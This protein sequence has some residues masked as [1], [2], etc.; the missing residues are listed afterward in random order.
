[1]PQLSSPRPLFLGVFLAVLGAVVW[2]VAIRPAPPNAPPATAPALEMVNDVQPDPA[3]DDPRLVFNTPFRNIKPGVN[4]VGDSRCAECHLDIC[5]SYHAH[6]MGR[7]AA[8]V[9]D[10]SPLEKYDPKSG[11]PF[12]SGVYQL[13][14]TRT[15]TGV[16]H[17]MTAKDIDGVALPEYATAANLA[18]G[19][20]TRGRSYVS[21]ENGSVWQ[22]PVSWFTS[23]SKW[24]L[25]PGFDLGS[26]GRRPI[27]A[28]C[29]LCHVNHVEAVRG[30]V[31]VYKEPLIALQ[32]S[33]GCERCH[34]P[35]DLHVSERLVGK[36]KEKIDTSIVNPKHLASDLQAS[37][38]QQCHLQGQERVRRRGRD[39]SEY[40]PGL[41]FDSFVTT[42]VRHPDLVEAN[43]SVGQFEQMEQS[44]CKTSTGGKLLCTSCH[45]PHKAPA[46]ADKEA[47][48]RNACQKCHETKGCVAPQAE[49][50]QKNDSCVACHMPKAGSS[51]IAHASVTDHRIQRRPVPPP[52]P[53]GMPPGE[54]PLSVF[55][56]GKVPEAEVKRDLGIALSRLT[57]KLP[58]GNSRQMLGAQAREVIGAALQKF[59]GDA[60]SWLAMAKSQAA[61]GDRNERWRCAERAVILEPN[62]EFALD[63]LVE[64]AMD[65]KRYDRA[66]EAADRLVSMNPRA[67]D[68][69]VS[70]ATLRLAMKEWEKAAED[71]Q[72]ALKIQPL[73]VQARLALAASMLRT[74]DRDGAIKQADT[75]IELTTQARQRALYRDWFEREKSLPGK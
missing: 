38:C 7:S 71:S 43:R 41:P 4:Y 24:D 15:A 27:V 23:E 3:P 32:T 13:A 10:A 62:S 26:G 35:G 17:K 73:N 72:A 33:I 12:T 21:V 42:F 9:N 51:N 70:R 37:I 5:D 16:L 66:A 11:N 52:A 28:G 48:Y 56:A 30:T 68:H 60:E 2:F 18:I 20:G 22:S 61:M 40:R 44:S 8:F 54:S 39:E 47:H 14:V 46:A 69:L 59:P 45:D 19:S 58:P 75:A 29:L 65:I 53:R 55:D 31:N 57:V 67:I 74:G 50:K 25:S 6:P 1:M 49:R 63:E 36:P 64:A 34:G